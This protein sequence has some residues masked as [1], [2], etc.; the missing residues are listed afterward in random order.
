MSPVIHG[1]AA[2]AFQAVAGEFARNFADRG[3][4]GASLAI[5]RDGEL[6]VDL[7]GGSLDGAASRP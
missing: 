6:V 7:W 4:V 1:N 2:A 5:V 3:D